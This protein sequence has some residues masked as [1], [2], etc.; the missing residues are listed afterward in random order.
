[1]NNTES[2][3][4]IQTNETKVIPYVIIK[5]KNLQVIK[6]KTNDYSILYN[7]KNPNIYLPQIIN[8]SFIKLIY[9]LNQ[10]VFEDCHIEEISDTESK[11]YILVKHYFKEL[12]LPKRYTYLNAKIIKTQTDIL[13][14][15]ATIYDE[16]PPNS[17]NMPQDATLLPMDNMDVSYHIINQHNVVARHDIHFAA[18][19][20]IP[21]FVEKFSLTLFSK[22]FI[23]TKQF[24]DNIK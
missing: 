24:I 20:D 1:M 3:Q 5:K 11:V 22:M 2:D 8:F 19:F 4:N 23:R 7:I 21:E 13:F 15:F 14:K 10:E 12:G 6:N 16:L 17:V 18:K 9:Q